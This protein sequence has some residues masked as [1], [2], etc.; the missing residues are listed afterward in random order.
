MLWGRPGQKGL[1]GGDLGVDKRFAVLRLAAQW[2]PYES[3]NLERI[4]PHLT[5]LEYGIIFCG[6]P[7]ELYPGKSV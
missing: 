4:R 2:L 3:G 7:R 1:P 6:I 5:P